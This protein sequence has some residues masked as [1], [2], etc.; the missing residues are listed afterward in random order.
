MN[1]QP[2]SFHGE[3]LGQHLLGCLRQAVGFVNHNGLIIPQQRLPAVLSV[4]GVGQQVIVVADLDGHG[5][6]I[7]LPQIPLVAAAAARRAEP[8]ALLGYTDLPPIKAGETGQ[9]VQIEAVL[10][11]P[12]NRGPPG[13]PVAAL[14]HLPL[15]FQ[16]AKI[17]H[18]A[19]LTLAQY[20]LD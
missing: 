8:R 20:S 1:Q 16:Q 13:K 10:R 6:A 11:L 2:H 12:Q 4:Q 3:L 15:T 9:L 5:G 19:L 14:R 17:A 18:K 7:G